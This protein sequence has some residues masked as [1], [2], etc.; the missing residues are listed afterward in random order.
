[1]YELN[2][3]GNPKFANVK[4][5]YDFWHYEVG[6]VEAENVAS[7]DLNSIPAIEISERIAMASRF[8]KLNIVA[9]DYA[10]KFRVGEYKQNDPASIAGLFPQ[11]SLEDEADPVQGISKL[12]YTLT[13]EDRLATTDFYKAVMKFD[14]DQHYSFLT[15]DLQS[16]Y[17]GKKQQ[18]QYEIDACKDMVDCQKLLHTRFGMA[19][20]PQMIEKEGLDANASL[21]LS[22]PKVEFRG[23]QRR[24]TL[25]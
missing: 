22:E 3:M 13:D 23:G 1:M 7:F 17:A 12:K 4:R 18:I 16:Q 2:D 24:D 11:T 14:L 10:I 5:I 15:S 9:N 8:A 19:T 6:F 25:F 21:D 20:H